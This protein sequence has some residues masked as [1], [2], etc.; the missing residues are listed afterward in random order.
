MP[1][2]QILHQANLNL[3]AENEKNAGKDEGENEEANAESSAGK[4]KNG[5]RWTQLL[6][7]NDQQRIQIEKPGD[8]SQTLTV[9]GVTRSYKIH[10]P[11]SYDPNQAMPTVVML[12][13]ITSGCRIL[14]G[15][16]CANECQSR[17][18]RFHR[19]LP[20]GQSHDLQRT[21]SRLERSQL[22]TVS[23][24]TK[25][26]TTSTSSI[27]SPISN[28]QN[29]V[30]VDPDR[31]AI[32]LVS[33]TGACSHRQCCKRRWQDCRSRSCW[34]LTERSGGSAGKSTFSARHTRNRRSSRAI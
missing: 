3:L 21:T 26:P 8:Y 12:H 11:Q 9:D 1:V 17:S 4:E 32:S 15:A 19:R 20:R 33:R 22:E 16:R 2:R 18:G 24:G 23:S 31:N 27:L 7:R 34:C 14:R 6:G 13:G 5:T 25:F 29:Q 28:V 30:T 10:V